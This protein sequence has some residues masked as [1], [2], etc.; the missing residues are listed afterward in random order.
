MATKESLVEELL[1]HEEELTADFY[2][3]IVMRNCN[4][5]HYKRRQVVWEKKMETVTSTR[6]LFR[7]ILEDEPPCAAEIKKTKKKRKAGNYDGQDLP[8]EATEPELA[9]SQKKRKRKTVIH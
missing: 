8:C 6:Q 4:V 9:P 2:G 1:K 7:D 5:N 3:R